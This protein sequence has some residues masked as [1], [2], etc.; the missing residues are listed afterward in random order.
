M[1]LL[2]VSDN[3]ENPANGNVHN[4]S[5]ENV[6]GWIHAE[7]SAQVTIKQVSYN[8]LSRVEEERARQ[9]AEL[10]V[11]QKAIA[12][13]YLDL[14]RLVNTP[15]PT[16]GNPYLFLQP[17]GFKDRS[18]F[19]GR[20]NEIAELFEHV[21]YSAIT[22][23]SGNRGTGKT[24]LL[25]AGL[26]PALLKQN[27]LPLMVCV[28]SES[29]EASI[30]KE[31]L[32]NIDGMPFLKA[33]S[34]TEFI[35]MVTSA[36]PDGKLLFVLVDD[37]EEF[38]ND[39][40]HTEVERNAFYNEWQR[41]FNGAASNAHWLFCVPSDLQYQLNF[42]KR[43]AQPHP[44]TISIPPFDR[45]SA[46]AAI[47]KPA[48]GRGINVDEG[49][50]NSILD[51][52]G[53]KNID[54]EG[55]QLVC[56][57][58]AGGQGAPSKDWTLE[59]YAAQ[60][61]ADG[62]LRDYLDRTIEELEPVER[63]PAWQ[64]LAVLAD[65]SMQT[66][67]EGHLVEKLKRYDVEEHITRRVLIDLESNSLIER[68]AAFR[69]TS[70]SLRPRIEKWKATRSARERARE[71]TIE[72]LQ[73]IRNS[74]L[75]GLLGGVVGFIAFDQILYDLRSLTGFSFVFFKIMLDT[76]IGALA[77]LLLVFS[78]DVA[79]ASYSGPRK[80]LAYLGA[81]L[82]G[83]LSLSLILLI[84]ANLSYLGEET[85][86]A[87]IPRAILEGG[88][89]GA[90]AGIGTAWVL[91]SQR[92]YWITIPASILLSGLT[93]VLVDSILGVLA[94]R[95]TDASLVTIGLAGTV[96]PGFILMAAMMGRHKLH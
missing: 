63:E 72:Q 15:P 28:N 23:L 89:W 62:I 90:A 69:L 85:F 8:Q 84:Y 10:D 75:R 86:I 70:D 95:F 13:K 64:V 68:G 44:N 30:K 3:S 32:P 14:N 36:L 82:G 26:I 77:G 18:R 47:L 21:T 74:A 65:P 16:R 56:Y 54:P 39:K 37:F 53:G 61:K 12:Q 49:V 27:H 38:F 81:A 22:F 66:S 50:I 91:K 42:F 29:L 71:E 46:R 78:V 2:P 1:T 57:M 17:F 7:G 40:E 96:L 31:L 55:L 34:L 59:Y 79:V 11:L 35:R 20:D 25:K 51:V 73:S 67:T 4:V 58:L 93:L 33:I 87:I 9:K 43:E 24:S 88:L 60:G 52:L 19:F 45:A 41:C 83:A 6:V 48:E 92:P 80:W 5:G 76:A 94:Q